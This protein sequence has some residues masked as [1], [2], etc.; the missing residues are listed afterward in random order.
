[1]DYST[2]II[3]YG[4]VYK[5]YYGYLWFAYVDR[6][7]IYGSYFSQAWGEYKYLVLVLNYLFSSTCTWQIKIKITCNCTWLKYPCTFQ[8]LL[9]YIQI[10]FVVFLVS[11]KM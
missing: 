3:L 4:L 1:M 8:L 2:L 7:I 5:D 10:T 6:Y 9:K 11:F